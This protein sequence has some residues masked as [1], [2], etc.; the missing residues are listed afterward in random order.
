MPQLDFATFPSQFLWLFIIFFL[1]YIMMSKVVVPGFKKIYKDR[2]NFINAEVSQAE[3]L[4]T[5][6]EKLKH[7][8]E[9]EILQAKE[10][11]TKA[12]NDTVSKL[13][14]LFDQKISEIEDNLA[15]DFKKQE[16]QLQSLEKSMIQE[17]EVI[18]ASS[19]AAIVSRLTKSNIKQSALNKYM[20]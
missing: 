19:A 6:A 16:K 17:L 2:Q 3:K 14:I 13:Q 9:T 15:E 10:A 11:H 20:N 1:Q 8:Y 18:A 7:D 4:I 5:Q 12:M